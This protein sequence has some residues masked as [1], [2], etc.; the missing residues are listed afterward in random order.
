MNE[1]ARP[2]VA[3]A[4]AVASLLAGPA[5]AEPACGDFLR[6]AGH[7]PAHLEFIDCR[8]GHVGQVRALVATYR[9]SGERAAAVESYLHRHTKMARLKR[10]CCIWEPDAKGRPRYGSLPSRTEFPYEV[11]MG[12]EENSV[13]RRADWKQIPWFTVSVTLPLES[14]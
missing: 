3:M 6:S 8:P 5:R 7:K 14:P 13:S 2:L 1:L 12:T 9:A 10:T 4:L 11:S